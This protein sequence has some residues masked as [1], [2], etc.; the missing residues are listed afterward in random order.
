MNSIYQEIHAIKNEKNLMKFLFDGTERDSKRIGHTWRRRGSIFCIYDDSPKK[1][2]EYEDIEL[3]KLGHKYLRFK[4]GRLK[5][6][7]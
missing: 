7:I 2:V 6:W 3:A 1:L 4:L 5:R